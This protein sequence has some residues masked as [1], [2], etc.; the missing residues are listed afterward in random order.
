[1]LRYGV[2]GTGMMGIEH[3]M[4]IAHID[5]GEVTAYAD[6]HEPS[7]IAAATIAVAMPTAMPAKV[8]GTM[9]FMINPV[10]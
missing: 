5:D 2:I 3:M 8:L 7:R 6:P 10:P 9:N 4:N 1:M